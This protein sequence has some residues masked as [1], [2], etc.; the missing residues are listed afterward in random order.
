MEDLKYIFISYSHRNESE[1]LKIIEELKKRGYNVWY[2]DG[3]DPG[4]EWDEYIASH[5]ENCAYFI[6]FISGEYLESE[7]CKDELNYSRD[8]NKKR[9]L[10]Y[11]ENVKLPGGMAMRL[12]RLQAIHKYRYAE[13]KD[14]YD[15]LVTA[16]GIEVA[17]ESEKVANEESDFGD[18]R[19]KG[20]AVDKAENTGS[21]SNNNDGSPDVNIS[22]EQNTEIDDTVNLSPEKLKKIVSDLVTKHQ[23]S[24]IYFTADT[25]KFI[26]KLPK[27]KEAYAYYDQ[28]ETPLML[29]DGTFGGSAKEEGFVLTNKALYICNSGTKG[30]F[31]L[32]QIVSVFDHYDAFFRLHYVC[33]DIANE[34]K[35]NGSGYVLHN[36][37]SFSSESTANKQIK[38]WTEFLE[39]IKEV[40]SGNETVTGSK[41]CEKEAEKRSTEAQVRDYFYGNLAGL[42]GQVAEKG[43]ENNGQT[44]SASSPLLSS[45]QLTRIITET[46][47]LFGLFYRYSVA[48]TASFNDNL[49]KVKASGITFDK[50]EIPLIY[51]KHTISGN[52]NDWFVLSNKALYMRIGN[53]R[54]NI[55]LNRIKTVFSSFDAK[56][57]LYY[58]CMNLKNLDSIY[59][60]CCRDEFTAD[61]LVKFWTRI[62]DVLNTESAVSDGI[63]DVREGVGPDYEKLI[64]HYTNQMAACV[65]KGEYDKMADYQFKIKELQKKKNKI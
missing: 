39:I 61:N 65:I 40:N 22:E 31:P 2:D 5:I 24:Y 23:L 38:F 9:L 37:I 28:S 33:M 16:D 12:N 53:S 50:N 58:I 64:A 47:K 60:S 46:V 34:E 29:E 17:F 48:G 3:I 15:K 19:I 30:K 21:I 18:D 4:T 10:V 7:N 6:A 62:L 49:A 27:A 14:F 54:G 32:E 43:C 52:A 1:V 55:P 8:L 26:K 59:V 35:K 44:T 41:V 36:Y 25:Q 51:E 13:E 57:R 45:E 20:T 56:T 42:L 63:A 11:L